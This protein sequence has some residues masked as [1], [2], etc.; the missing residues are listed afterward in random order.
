MQ[1]TPE[2]LD[3]FHTEGYLFFPGPVQP[4]GSG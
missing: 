4:R 3:R 1:L 2:Q